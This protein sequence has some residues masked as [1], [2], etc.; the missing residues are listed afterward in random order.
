MISRLYIRSGILQTRIRVWM[1]TKGNPGLTKLA[2]IIWWGMQGWAKVFKC[3]LKRP[4]KE[5]R[6]SGKTHISRISDIFHR[7]ECSEVQ[8]I[9]WNLSER[10]S[11]IWFWM[12]KVR[13]T[14]SYNELF[15]HKMSLSNKT[16]KQLLW[17][18][19]M[20]EQKQSVDE[21]FSRYSSHCTCFRA[22]WH[23]AV[24]YVA[25]CNKSWYS[26]CIT[27]QALSSFHID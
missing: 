5:T 12:S 15:T 8:K 1:I 27:Q 10:I 9:L 26:M 18:K 4:E 11:R 25:Y 13:R 24:H 23:K 22:L 6:V 14:K 19:E 20:N 2:R 17:D 3:I 16:N 7:K 21:N